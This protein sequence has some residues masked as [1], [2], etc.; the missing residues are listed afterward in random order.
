MK[1]FTLEEIYSSLKNC[2]LKVKTFL[3]YD[4][5]L[6]HLRLKAAQ[7]EQN[8]DF[9]HEILE[10]SKAIFNNDKLFFEPL[11]SSISF[12]A[13]PKKFIEPENEDSYLK[14]SI[15]KHQKVSD[16]NFFIDCDIRL[17]ILDMFYMLCIKKISISYI[18][19]SS[20][21]AGRLK[22]GILK[23]HSDELI[24]GIDF[25]SNRCFVNYYESYKKWRDN[26]FDKVEKLAPTNKKT[27][28]LF[29]LDI[30]K[31]YYSANFSF[32]EL[33][34]K[35]CNDYRLSQILFIETI[36]EKVYSSY[37]SLLKDYYIFDKKDDRCYPFPIG[38]FSPVV[39]RE[40]YLNNLDKL[41]KNNTN[42]IYYGRYV[43]D[44]LFLVADSFN[45]S[46]SDYINKYLSDTGILKRINSNKKDFSFVGY[47]NLKTSFEQKDRFFVFEKQQEPILVKAFKEILNKTSSEESL[48]PDLEFID[49][50]FE[51]KVYGLIFNDANHA[52][53]NLNLIVSDI[54][55]ATHYIRSMIK[56]YK[57]TSFYSR[58]QID[59]FINKINNFFDECLI[60]QYS[61]S[62]TLLFEAMVILGS[63]HS[64]EA[65]ALLDKIRKQ[66]NNTDSYL[67]LDK[68]KYRVKNISKLEKNIKKSLRDSLYI[69]VATA[70]CLKPLAFKGKEEKFQN[71]IKVLRKSNLFDYT[72]GTIH[73]STFL[74]EFDDS[75]SLIEPDF[76]YYLDHIKSFNFDNNKTK[77]SPV[78][79]HY[80][81][82]VLIELLKS[83]KEET[84][85]RQNV[86]NTLYCS[87]NHIKSNSVPEII[88][89]KHQ[90]ENE[91]TRIFNLPTKQ[92]ILDHV[93][94]GLPNL[95]YSEK[96]VTKTIFNR[97]LSFSLTKKIQIIKV[98]LEAHRKQVNFLIFPELYC[99][100]E[101]VYDLFNFA[102]AFGI[103]IIF[104]SLYLINGKQAHNCIVSLLSFQ[105]GKYKYIYPSYREKIHY[106]YFEKELL[107]SAGYFTSN[108]TPTIDIF[109]YA[110]YSL[111]NLLCYELTDIYLR[112]YLKGK[113]DLLIVPELNKDT[114]YFSNIIESTTRDLYCFVIQENSAYYGDCRIVGPYD[115]LH[116]NKIQF[117]GGNDTFVV[118][119]E[120]DFYS[121]KNEKFLLEN[122]INN[123]LMDCTSCLK[124]KKKGLSTDK[125]INTCKRCRA[126]RQYVIET[127]PGGDKTHNIKPKP[128][129][130]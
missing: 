118:A 93:V 95:Y 106:P 125:I 100:I 22:Q 128:P 15:A 89:T 109:R 65:N 75:I 90:K 87:L 101:W 99:P 92:S 18:D 6:L 46:N 27:M 129:T 43:D 35:L 40:I 23:K 110:H 73:L 114:N 31:F 120:I 126:K 91:T 11:I 84:E 112:N 58:I 38:L 42:T 47:D 115:T 39:L 111:S 53:R 72:L 97:Y 7:F 34:D 122:R 121:F 64:K 78:F 1:E 96:D 25:E 81:D 98:L 21:F 77:Y 12:V 60:I 86:T 76:S 9:E 83:I 62:W 24:D 8:T 20:S 54:S 113:I 69:S 107:A 88:E 33:H 29:S 37:Y 49:G 80:H 57:G 19:F 4:K 45:S 117:K 82:L 52:L 85:M 50:D 130:I 32:K 74:E 68:K 59:D 51:Q 3:C 79:F 5:T 55:S 30:N 66:I 103:S 28:V 56:L 14:L 48:L 26:A 116:K 70:F 44:I 71:I 16:I 2:F 104:G 94:F 41:F 17:L 10:L 108:K 61:Q 127:T 36:V 13:K 105:I 67:D 124:V 63:K 102:K 119:Y 123:C